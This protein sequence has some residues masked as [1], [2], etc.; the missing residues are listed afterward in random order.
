VDTDTGTPAILYVNWGDPKTHRWFVVARL[1]R[2]GDRRAQVFEFAYVAGALEA[3]KHGFRPFVSFPSLQEVVNSRELLPFFRNRVMSSGR[4][5]YASYVKELGLEPDT[6]DLR[7][8]A[9]SGG[10]RETERSDVTE[11]F[12]PPQRRQDGRL[13]SHFFVRG[14][15]HLPGAAELA[16]RLAKDEQ[17]FCLKD[18][19]NRVNPKALVLRTESQALLGY[20]PDYLCEDVSALLD[21]PSEVRF[22]VVQVNDPN[23]PVRLRVLCRFEATVPAGF[24]PFAGPQF[25]PLS[26]EAVRAAA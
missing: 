10:Q 12:A 13:E 3:E 20:L 8:L 17:L 9:R 5:D 6:D 25:T 11:L 15:G 14:L 1:I 4:P 23:V 18:V 2:R 21:E 26:G 16:T 22:S 7:L 19:Q 24:Q